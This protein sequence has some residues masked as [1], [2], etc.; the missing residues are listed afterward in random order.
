MFVKVVFEGL[1]EKG[2]QGDIAVDDFQIFDG[3]CTETK[4]KA[5]KRGVIKS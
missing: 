3:D 1:M 2:Y 5:P 4:V